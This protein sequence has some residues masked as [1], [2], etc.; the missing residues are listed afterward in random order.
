MLRGLLSGTIVLLAGSAMVVAAPKDDVTAAA[1]KLSEATNYSWKQTSPPPAAA[2]GGDNAQPG[3]RRGRRGGFGFGGP[4]EG[5]MADGFTMVTTGTGDTARES[6]SKGDK[7]VIKTQDGWQTPEEIRAAA[8][9]N[10]NGNGNGGR[11]GR[12]G[13]MG[14]ARAPGGQAATL[15]KYVGDLKEADGAFQGDLSEEGAKG[16]LMGGGRRGGNAGN[17][18]DI[19]DAKGTAKFWVKDGNISKFEYHVTGTISFNGNDRPIDRTVTVEITD[20]G[21][22][23]IAVPDDAKKKL[24]S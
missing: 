21:S 12:G 22:T 8:D 11:R 13:A 10:G 7:T 3:G 24:E 16:F 4:V 6:I 15:A 23:K 5:K 18:P 1:Q 14:G 2:P 19:S 17:G 20:V 9:A